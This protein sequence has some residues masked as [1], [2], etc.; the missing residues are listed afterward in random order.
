MKT[1]KV[2]V[3]VAVNWRID[4]TD[5]RV[6]SCPMCEREIQHGH[7]SNCQLAAAIKAAKGAG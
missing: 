7:D 5:Y 2:R 1:V 3:A 4:E 6:H